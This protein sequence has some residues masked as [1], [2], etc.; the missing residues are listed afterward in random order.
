[1]TPRAVSLGL[2]GVMVVCG[3]AFFTD[4]ILRQTFMVGTYL[5]L[6]V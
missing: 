4:H 3:F 6:P 1:M 2:L 5:P